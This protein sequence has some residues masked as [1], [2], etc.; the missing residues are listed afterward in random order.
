MRLDAIR[1]STAARTA[2]A[3]LLL[4]MFAITLSYGTVYVL[5]SRDATTRLRVSI[6]EK[7]QQV[8]AQLREPDTEMQE[9][10]VSADPEEI[11]LIYDRDGKFLGGNAAAIPP[12]EGWKVV[13]A[14]ELRFTDRTSRESDR[15]LLFGERS[16]AYQVVVGEGLY[17][18]DEIAGI[19]LSA[20]LWGIATVLLV[21][22]GGALFL[23]GRATKRLA[24]S[25][26]AL[27]AFSE[28]NLGRRLPLAGAGDDLD[29]VSAAVNAALARIETL[30][31]T[32]QQIST[33]IAHDLKSPLTRLR[34]TLESATFARREPGDTTLQT[35]IAQAD[36]IVETFEGLLRIANIEAGARRARFGLVDL[37]NVLSTVIDAFGPAAEDAG[38]RLTLSVADQATV[39]GDRELLTQLFANLVENAI[40]HGGG[41]NVITVTEHLD[42]GQVVV[43][44][45]DRGLGIPEA[46]YERVLRRFYRLDRSRSTPGSGLGL[47]LVKAIAD[48]HCANLKL[49]DG[50]PGLV[51]TLRFPRS[52]PISVSLASKAR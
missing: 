34:Q 33:D 52:R 51:C 7:M 24:D 4:F 5:A 17:L 40:R 29:R 11:R 44:V 18:G 31:N 22:G 28:G 47:A 49:A 41:G 46:E 15:Y 2:A 48:L 36:A 12:F 30:L 35:A 1:R 16:D 32:V 8:E 38:Q 14:H 10:A 26:A 20:F 43:S 19:L 39:H 27:N 23:A 25:E 3:Y 50:N 21:G 9:A 6:A 45:S 13:D 42:V 37:A